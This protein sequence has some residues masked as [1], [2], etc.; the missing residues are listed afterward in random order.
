[1]TDVSANVAS[2]QIPVVWAGKE[3]SFDPVLVASLPDTELVK[4]KPAFYTE[5]VRGHPVKYM[6]VERKPFETLSKSYEVAAAAKGGADR[7]APLRLA[8][9]MAELSEYPILAKAATFSAGQ[10]TFGYPTVYTAQER[11][12]I[13]PQ[14]IATESDVYWVELA[15]SFRDIDIANSEKLIF[16]VSLS[17]GIVAL[18]L[19]PLRFDKEAVVK[20]RVQSPELKA[21][22]GNLAVELGKVF[23]RE[24]VYT[25]MNPIIIADGLQESEFAW[26]LSEEA[27]QPGAK[28]FVAVIRVPKG[29]QSV[30][31]QLQ[32]SARTKPWFTQ[33]DLVSTQPKLINLRLR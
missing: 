9:A 19:V 22:L 28:R 24:V 30:T 4:H 32:A 16:R 33:G 25:S 21:R 5:Y 23:E 12:L 29:R 27:V 14:A 20:Q 2:A 10:V 8:T 1:L 17:S 31:V 7:R 18:E 6:A 26:S 15:V 3:M 13:V 11:K